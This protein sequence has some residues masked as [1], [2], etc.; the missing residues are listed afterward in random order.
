MKKKCFLLIFFI[1]LLLITSVKA[2]EYGEL[3]SLEYFWTQ[4]F[5]LPEEWLPSQ[6]L[7]NFIFNFMVP[8]L[9]LFTILLGILRQI[10]IFWRTPAIEI[11][12]A[13]AMAFLTLPS[14][15]FITFVNLTLA[16]A[17][18]WGYLMFLFMFIGGSLFYSLAFVRRWR[19]RADI[20]KH[21]RSSMEYLS[22]EEEI[23]SAQIA[24]LYH[25]LSE[26]KDPEEINRINKKIKN[27][28]ERL[29]FVREKMRSLR[30]SHELY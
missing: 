28:K 8:F 26:A 11:V 6:N 4:V 9:A 3:W 13:F 23:L 7:R 22:N 20:Y 27:L 25:K 2:Q 16:F 17:G 29:D 18:I 30:M 5:G 12:I 14:K 19:G 10:R 1:F 24:D 21:F 15:V